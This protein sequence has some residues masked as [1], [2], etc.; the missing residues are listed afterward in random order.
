MSVVASL[1]GVAKSYGG[2]R[3]LRPTTLDLRPG[4]VGLLGPNGAG[5]T[6]MLR[7]LSTALPP[8]EGRIVVSGFDVT[9]SHADRVLFLADC[10]IVDELRSPSAEVILD[11]MK[12]LER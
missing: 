10:H 1:D 3:A 12:N 2:L 5:K 9:A 7:L 11:R 4:V 8:S 6:T